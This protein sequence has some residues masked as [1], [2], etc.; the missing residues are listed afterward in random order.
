MSSSATLPHGATRK[1]AYWPWLLWAAVLIGIDQFTKQWI[2]SFYEYG[3]WTPI[4]GFFNI[5]RAHNTGAAF[6]FLAEHG[7]WQRWLFV[8]IGVIAT[9]LIVWQLRKHPEQKF[10]CFAIASILGGAIGNVVDRLM[11]GYVVDFLDF[12]WAGWHYP[13][14]NVADIAIC[15]GAAC[16]VL[17]EVLRSRRARRSA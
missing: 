13:A 8:G 11:H 10:F 5:V 16:L 6:S 15:T 9:L 3:D 17:D 2:L 12:H 1:P 7:G 14:F 4:T